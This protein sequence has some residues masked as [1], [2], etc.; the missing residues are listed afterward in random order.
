M[1]KPSR[2]AG[3]PDFLFN[4]AFEYDGTKMVP[5]PNTDRLLEAGRAYNP[6]IKI[7]P[8]NSVE[9]TGG[10]PRWGSGGGYY[11]FTNPDTI[12]IDPISADTHV[13]AHE[14]G[15]ALAPSELQAHHGG[16]P[17][18]SI[19]KFDKQ[20]NPATNPQHPQHA[21][22]R[23]GASLR[24]GYELAGKRTMLEE[25]SAQGFAIGLQE[26]LGIPY[27]NNMYKSIH[28][29]PLSFAGQ[30]IDQY[31]M[32]S[33]MYKDDEFNPSE[34]AELEAISKSA[35][36]AIKREYGKAYNRGLVIPQ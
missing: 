25:A 5:T 24:A 3:G 34:Q 22:Q 10:V 4:P 33:G 6:D 13:V 30:G 18:G 23:T 29:Y 9:A 16:G 1:G 27:T 36:P 2:K 11:D 28:D 32:A 14:L 31:K 20:F 21:P 15:H 17:K 35:L 8:Y 19:E 12:H 7:R 26:R